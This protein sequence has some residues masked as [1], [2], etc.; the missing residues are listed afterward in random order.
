MARS[1]RCPGCRRAKDF[2]R[3]VCPRCCHGTVHAALPVVTQPPATQPHPPSGAA[4]FPKGLAGY[5]VGFTLALTLQYLIILAVD[6]LVPGRAPLPSVW[7]SL[8][9]PTLGGML[10]R[11]MFAER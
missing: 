5:L 1:W 3:S 8:L 7:V 2:E 11:D 10:G 4:Q 6:S 9:I